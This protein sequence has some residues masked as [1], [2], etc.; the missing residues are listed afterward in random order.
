LL[1]IYQPRFEACDLAF[2]HVRDTG[3]L[4][5]VL[6]G[7]QFGL[8]RNQMLEA[9]LVKFVGQARAAGA[10]DFVNR[11]RDRLARSDVADTCPTESRPVVLLD[12]IVVDQGQSA[13]PMRPQ[14]RSN[15]PA[16][17]ANSHDRDVFV[18]ELRGGPRT[19]RSVLPFVRRWALIQDRLGGS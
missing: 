11:E 10:V 1:A 19:E 18:C 5:R 17:A 3:N 12:L 8:R 16:K 2:T 6:A 9:E 13:N 15:L 14:Q 7:V 4:A